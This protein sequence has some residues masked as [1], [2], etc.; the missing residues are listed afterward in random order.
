M[1]NWPVT[2]PKL[3]GRNCYRH[4]L[5]SRM[6]AY[7]SRTFQTFSRTMNF[8]HRSQPFSRI[9]QVCYEP[10][11][12]MSTITIVRLRIQNVVPDQAGI[13]RSNSGKTRSAEQKPKLIHLENPPAWRCSSPPRNSTD[14]SE[15]G[16]C[17]TASPPGEQWQTSTKHH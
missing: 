16:A 2:Q 15:V 13:T 12:N 11:V 10:Q 5:I 7:N 4:V 6:T 14:S 8:W 9:S 1:T 3:A 17:V